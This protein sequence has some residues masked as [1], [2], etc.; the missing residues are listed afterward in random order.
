MAAKLKVFTWSDGFHAFTVAVSSKPK[1]LAA[2]G[3]GQDLFKSGLAHEVASGPSHAAARAAPGEV[4]Q[5][6]EAVDIGALAKAPKACPKPGPGP[7]RKARVKALEASLATMDADHAEAIAKIGRQ[8]GEL[9]GR[10]DA[11]RSDQSRERE[12]LVRCLKIERGKL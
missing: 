4:I 6:G 10:R 12:E 5:T 3:I 2:W 1:A 7:A 9:E 11:L 8:I